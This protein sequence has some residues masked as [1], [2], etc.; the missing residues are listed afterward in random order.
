MANRIKSKGLKLINIF[1]KKFVTVKFWSQSL[2]QLQ[3]EVN[4]YIAPPI[5]KLNA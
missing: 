1:A 5:Q 3:V 4:I 2:F